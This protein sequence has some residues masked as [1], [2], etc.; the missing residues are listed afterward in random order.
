[1][2]SDQNDYENFFITFNKK[3]TLFNHEL[4][5]EN[6]HSVGLIYKSKICLN[7]TLK[8]VKERPL[9]WLKV[10]FM[11]IISSHGKL[12][13]DYGLRPLAYNEYFS[14]YYDLDKKNISKTLRKLILC[15]YMLLVYIFFIKI[16]FYSK[17]KLF[18]K[19]SYFC[20]LLFYSYIIFSGHFFNGVEHAKITYAGSFVNILFV[21]AIL[22]VFKNKLTSVQ[23]NIKHI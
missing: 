8:L 9:H 10:R 3:K 7:E 12:S 2:N 14:F 4:T 13:I 5:K 15:S 21:I 22:N 6:L 20:I 23:K 19:K 1:M 17:E 16:I 18:I 11:Q